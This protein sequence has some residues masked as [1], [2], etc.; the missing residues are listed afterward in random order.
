MREFWIGFFIVLVIWQTP[1]S[2]KGPFHGQV[3][4][5]I[6]RSFGTGQP[7]HLKPY[8]PS[9]TKIYLSIPA[10]DIP[11]GNY[12]RS[13]IISMLRQLFQRV[14]TRGMHLQGGNLPNLQRGPI[15]GLWRFKNEQTNR[16]IETTLY[17]TI[18]SNPL[19]PIIKSIR[20]DAP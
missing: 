8:L 18:T 9:D 14:A 11:A 13:Q 20:G 17:F 15:R 2:A 19:K 3:G 5:A 4:T 16:E 6:E 1:G 12:S 7:E 10:A